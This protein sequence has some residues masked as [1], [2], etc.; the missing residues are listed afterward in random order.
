MSITTRID[1]RTGDK[2][3]VYLNFRNR[4]TRAPERYRRDARV[5]TRAGAVA[6]ERSV[7][8]YWVEHGTIAPLL[9]APEADVKTAVV[10]DVKWEDA[11]TRAVEVYWPTLKASTGAGYERLLDTGAFGCFE[12]LPLSSVVEPKLVAEWDKTVSARGGD[13]T[14]RN[15][16][17]V[18]R[19]ILGAA[20]TAGWITPEMLCRL[21]KLPKVGETIVE[22]VP[23]DVALAIIL[24]T[25]AVD[26]P[27]SF[28]AAR[29]AARRAFAIMFYA[30]LRSGEV[31][32]LKWSDIDLRRNVIHVRHART[33]GVEDVPKG[34]GARTIPLNGALRDLLGDAPKDLDRYVAPTAE[35]APWGD[36][37]LLQA[38]VRACDR[39]GVEKQKAH[40]FRHSFV[41]N[42]FTRGASAVT[43]QKLAGHQDL[44]TTQRYAHVGDQEKIDAVASLD[45]TN[46]I[47]FRS[48]AG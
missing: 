7:S 5:Q 20:K 23:T 36:S 1:K 38:L 24:E 29:V 3:V 9:R 39:L 17:V 34:G 8:A 28:R 30:G 27:P 18:L 33:A 26:L 48:K 25:D 13:S 12:G 15:F 40:G 19:S 11:V 41:S 43:V 31:R 14:R 22:A 6:E 10:E 44:K 4:V 46:V 2:L 47:P 32:A 42:L 16:H 45:F 21:P 35:G 37:A